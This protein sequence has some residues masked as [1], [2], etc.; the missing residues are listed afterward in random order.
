MVTNLTGDALSSN[1]IHLSWNLPNQPGLSEETQYYI[2][3][4]IEVQSNDEWTFFAVK[5]HATIIS[6]LPY[7]YYKCRVAIVGNVTYQYSHNVTVM[8]LQA[9]MYMYSYYYV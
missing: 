5:S 3:H 7:N 6:L 8:T 4:C 9:G 1:S 2:V